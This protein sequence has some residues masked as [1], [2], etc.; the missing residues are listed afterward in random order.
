MKI[1]SG[2]NSKHLT[3]KICDLLYIKPT[4]IKIDDFKD[5]EIL[6]M[7]QESV[8]GEKIFIVQSTNSPAEN[9]MEL[10]LLIDAC[11][12][13]SALEINCIIPYFGYGRQDRR[14][15]PRVPVGSKLMIDLI[16]KAIYPRDGRIITIDLHAMQIQG[17]ANIPF[18]H[19]HGH[20]VF[21]NFLQNLKL[22]NVTLCS[23]DVGGVKRAKKYL[24]IKPEVGLVLIDK[25]RVVPNEVSNFELIGDVHDKNVIIIDDMIDTGGTLFGASDYLLK[26][27]ARSVRAIITH[28]L[29]SSQASF[30]KLKKSSLKELVITDTIYH[31]YKEL[32]KKSRKKLRIVSVA[33]LLAEVIRRISAG[34]SIDALN[35]YFHILKHQQSL[36]GASPDNI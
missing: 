2:R 21:Y 18:D 9:I 16:E 30:E 14:D 36:M 25:D 3:Q 5:G 29:F 26:Q 8:R 6:P 20:T 15:M 23:P 32:E 4:P 28:P 24:K 17:F 34:D 27:G 1:L 11:K 13:S 7:I 12:R 35:E 10:L 19:I 31:D 22:D 33:P